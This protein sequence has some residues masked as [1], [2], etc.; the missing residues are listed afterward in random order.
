MTLE[1]QVLYEFHNFRLNPAEHS[2]MS[3]G[4]A[5]PLTPKSFDILLTLNERN[6]RLVTKDELMKKIWPDSFVEEANLTVNVS[7]LRKAL[8]D[9]PEHQQYIET[10]PKLGYRF[11]AP[12][13]EVRNG[14]TEAPPP[15][16][17]ETN[18]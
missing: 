11:I 4:K 13:K 7:A 3:G 5:V 14:R 9:T 10:V 18:L 6:G 8:G 2:L 16:D 15:A 17:V 1:T 12:V